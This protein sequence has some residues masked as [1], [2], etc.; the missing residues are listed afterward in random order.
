MGKKLRLSETP[1]RVIVRLWKYDNFFYVLARNRK[2]WKA[3]DKAKTRD[4]ALLAIEQYH[5][6]KDVRWSLD[7]KVK[8][9]HACEV[10]GARKLLESHH[11]KPKEQ[12]PELRHE[13]DNGECTCLWR[14]ALLHKDN[15]VIQNMI[16]LRLVAALT[17][18]N[19][20]PLTKCQKALLGL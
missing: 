16:L 3:I 5:M 17:E 14:H 9:F 8:A 20:K 6:D 2:G 10:C 7:V 11:I 15:P 1:P 12:Y 4:E 13:L 18:R 19:C